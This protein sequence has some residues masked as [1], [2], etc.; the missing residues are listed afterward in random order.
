[1]VSVHCRNLIVGLGLACAGSVGTAHAVP[2]TFDFTGG[3][4]QQSSFFN[5][6]NSGLNLKVSSNIWNDTGTTVSNTGKVGRWS[7]GLGI[8]SGASNDEHFVDGKDKNELLSLSFSKA[9][10]I[11]SVT[12]SYNDSDDDFA[13]FFDKNGNGSLAGDL[14]WKKKDIPGSSFYGTYTFAALESMNAIGKLFGIGAFENNDNFK[15]ASI[16]VNNAPS[17]VPLP[18][19]LP[20]LISALGAMGWRARRRLGKKPQA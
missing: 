7:T 1:M 18:G 8:L 4:G 10:K 13:F 14:V 17:A 2:V 12:F 5:F 6:T 20:L 16:T 9:V 19:A 11:I 3:S 15:V